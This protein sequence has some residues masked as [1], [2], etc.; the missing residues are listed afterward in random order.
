MPMELNDLTREIIGA[1]TEVHKQLGPGMMESAYEECL[2]YELAGWG[3]SIACQKPV[4]VVYKEVKLECGYRID[5]LV[6]DTVVIELTSVDAL[7]P[8]HEA[9]ILTYL[10][11]AKRKVGLLINL[12]VTVL[13]NGIKRYVM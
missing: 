6:N 11:F 9:Q 4:P 8:I 3:L 13:K 7:A 12:N 1:A 10:R 2:S 5:I